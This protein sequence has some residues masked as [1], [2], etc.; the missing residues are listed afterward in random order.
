[1]T[2]QKGP[3]PGEFLL[4]E[5]EDGH[6]R[7]TCRFVSD[8]LWLPQAGMAELFQTS[9]QNI[10]KHLKGIFAEGELAEEAVVNYWLTTA[11]DGK[12][13]RVAHY[14]LDAV[15]AVGYR[16][17]SPRGTQFRRWA[18]ERLREYLVKGFT[19]DDERLKNPPVGDSAVPDRFD[20]LLE[21]IQDIR[22][23]E[24]RMYLRVREIFAMAADYAPTLPQTTK[25]FRIIQNKL[26]FT[27]TGKTAA[28]LIRER[29]DSAR[30]NM[31]LTTWKSGNVQKADVTVA[32]NYLNESEVG[33]LNRIV[34][35]WL[36]FAEDQA[37][38]RKE[39]FL[40]DWAEKLDAFL[41]FNDR[42]VLTDAGHISKNQA[43]AHAEHEYERFAARRRALLEAEGAEFNVRVLE[44]AAKAL[45]ESEK[46][47]KK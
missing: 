44:D 38:R 8:T 15:L 19:L 35:M 4:Y 22:A 24:R 36:D 47:K 10:A 13:Y 14:D 42:N 25:F 45:P 30:P 21:R 41:M 12:N 3:V 37:R 16:V 27:V 2:E 20:E 7:V 33:E 29:A 34:V 5:T 6:T 32:K 40:N 23:S 1:M 28:E 46:K 31:G 17:R 39:I 26:H 9:K 11:S 18:T 43:D